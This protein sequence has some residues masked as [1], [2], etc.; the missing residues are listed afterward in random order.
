MRAN[1][2]PDCYLKEAA[3]GRLTLTWYE[4]KTVHT[5]MLGRRQ[6]LLFNKSKGHGSGCTTALSRMHCYHY[7]VCMSNTATSLCSDSTQNLY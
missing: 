3:Q 6:G 7:R 4:Y 2:S 1:G 5:T